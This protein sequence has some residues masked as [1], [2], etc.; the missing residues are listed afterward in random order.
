MLPQSS[1]PKYWA[2]WNYWVKLKSPSLFWPSKCRI[3]RIKYGEGNQR[4]SR[5][6][7]GKD[8]KVHSTIY[9]PALDPS[10]LFE[11]NLKIHYS[12]PLKPDI[13]D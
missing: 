6:G 5:I 3:L 12:A 1:S 9:T 13:F 2:T 8:F 4:K 11:A 7:H 10:G